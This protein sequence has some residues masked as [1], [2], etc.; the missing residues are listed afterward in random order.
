MYVTRLSR[1]RTELKGVLTTTSYIRAKPSDPLSQDLLRIVM[2][3]F[4]QQCAQGRGPPQDP[5]LDWCHL[6]TFPPCA[7]QPTS[8]PLAFG[9]AHRTGQHRPSAIPPGSCPHLHVAGARWYPICW[10]ALLL[11]AP[12]RPHLVTTGTSTARV[13]AGAAVFARFRAGLHSN[14]GWQ[15]ARPHTTPR[16]W[17]HTRTSR[18]V[19]DLMH[20]NAG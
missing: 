4:R 10:A 17:H 9:H 12:C 14:S 19:G 1:I 20:S 6:A 7:C 16:H 8:C 3:G 18:E 11:Y 15:P 5:P 13:A 2:D